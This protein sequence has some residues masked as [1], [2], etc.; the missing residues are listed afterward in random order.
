MIEPG[1]YVKLIFRNGTQAEGIVE[2]WSDDISILVSVDNLSKFVV[3]HTSED[4]LGVKVCLEEPEALEE[5][6]TSFQETVE[7]FKEMYDAPSA[8]DSSEPDL[9]RVHNLAQLKMLMNE[10]EKKI[11]AGKLKEHT[12]SE[13]R[14]SQYGIPSFIKKPSTK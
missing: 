10:Q 2:S 1:L 7:H 6:E 11:V 13:V 3:L 5:A 4:L 12:V 14:S 8:D 9:N